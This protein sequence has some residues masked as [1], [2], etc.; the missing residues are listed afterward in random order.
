MVTD[1]VKDL[2]VPLEEYATVS[3]R[4]ALYEAVLALERAQEEISMTCIP[5]LHRAILVYDDNSKPDK[6]IH[7]TGHDTVQQVLNG[8]HFPIISARL[9]SRDFLQNR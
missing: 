4:A 5:Y 3:H 2:M 9:H 6:A 8:Q 1:K 7:A